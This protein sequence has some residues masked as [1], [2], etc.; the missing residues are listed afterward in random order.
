MAE[1]LRISHST[2]HFIIYSWNRAIWWALF[3]IRWS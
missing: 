3:A 2:V 1:I